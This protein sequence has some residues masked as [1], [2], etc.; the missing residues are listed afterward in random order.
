MT[1]ESHYLRK[2]THLTFCSLK[3]SSKSFE[4][5]SEEGLKIGLMTLS[6]NSSSSC[7]PRTGN[8]GMELPGFGLILYGFYVMAKS[9]PPTE[10][11]FTCVCPLASKKGDALSIFSDFNA[12]TQSTRKSFM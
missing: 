5:R 9:R 6:E 7:L 4:K 3:I 1:L 8:T 12:A 11:C 10:R 2:I